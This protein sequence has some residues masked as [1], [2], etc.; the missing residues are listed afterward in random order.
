MKIY[1]VCRE[2]Y[3]CPDSTIIET[4]SS[5]EKAEIFRSEYLKSQKW[6]NNHNHTECVV[7]NEYEVR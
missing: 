7:I 5:K 4:F 2:Y 3:D 6:K 1:Q